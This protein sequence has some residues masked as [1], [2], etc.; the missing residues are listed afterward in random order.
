MAE[1]WVLGFL[2]GVGYAA[3]QDGIDPLN[4]VDDQ[5]V[6]AWVDNYCRNHPLNL[7]V[8]AAAA[9]RVAHPH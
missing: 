6:W 9:F 3:N 5:G 8:T 4:G 7:V 2:S 1:Q